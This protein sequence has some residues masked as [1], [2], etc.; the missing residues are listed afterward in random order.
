M[1]QKTL[2]IH[3]GHYKTGTT[4]L[5]QMMW[6]NRHALEAAGVDYAPQLV[7]RNKHS[8]FAFSILKEA[9]VRSLMHGYDRSESAAELWSG[10]FKY[11]ESSSASSVLISSEE[12]ARIGGYPAA[13]Q[14]LSARV[15]A[16]PQNIKIKVICYLR[17][18]QE[19]LRSWYNQLVKMRI[20]TPQFSD[21]LR[22]FIEPV[23]FD[24]E[25]LLGIWVACV[26]SRNLILRPYPSAPQNR[27]AIF[28]DFLDAVG[29]HDIPLSALKLPRSNPN[30]RLDG[31][32]LEMVRCM[33]NSGLK[34]VLVQKNA[35]RASGYIAAANSQSTD[36]RRSVEDV[37]RR[38]AESVNYI[39]GL[40][41]S[42][43]SAGLHADPLKRPSVREDELVRLVEFLSGEISQLKQQQVEQ[44][45]SESE[46]PHTASRTS[47]R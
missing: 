19:H 42:F 35:E 3:I 37:I 8:A 38:S 6:T 34:Q 29:L 36:E 43:D 26:G 28:R 45:S 24:Y 15:S 31:T 25:V 23:H 44:Q 13:C 20:K 47:Q 41:T 39:D 40:G 22:S 7:N 18:P 5:Q 32:T 4:A 9:N 2:F 10:L 21:A 11:V 27:T 46:P 16:A 33:Q 14:A 12:F 17:T 30:P 1:T